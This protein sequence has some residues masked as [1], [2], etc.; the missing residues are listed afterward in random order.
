MDDY[1]ALL[2]KL[3]EEVERLARDLRHLRG[4]RVIRIMNVTR[5][6][7]TPPPT[8]I[9]TCGEN[10]MEATDTQVGWCE[11]TQK[12]I[13]TAHRKAKSH[14]DHLERFYPLNDLEH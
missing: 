4:K 8:P 2:E 1:D 9:H 14:L 13:E 12:E 7:W 5:D 3:T 10:C 11:V 6:T